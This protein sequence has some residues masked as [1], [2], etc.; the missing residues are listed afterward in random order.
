MAANLPFVDR[1]QELA[2][3]K[4]LIYKKTPSFVVIKGRRRIGKSRLIY[5]FIKGFPAYHFIGLAPEKETTAQSQRD[6]FVRQL[7]EQVELPP[8]VANDWGDIFTWLGKL[9]AEGRHIIVLDEVTWMGSFDSTFLGKLEVVWEKYFSKNPEL[10]V[11]LCGSVSQWIEDNILSSTGY[12]GR[13]ALEITL[14]EFSLQ[15]CDRFLQHLN[16][17]GSNLEKLQLLSITGGVP[18]YIE[19]FNPSISVS[20]NIKTLCFRKNALLVKEFERLFHDLFGKRGNIYQHIIQC[21]ADGPKEYNDIADMLNYTRSGALSKYLNELVISGFV[22][23][24][25]AWRLN[26]GADTKVSQYRLCDNYLRFYLKCIEPRISQINKDLFRERSLITIPGWQ[27]IMGM[28]FE[29]LVLHNRRLIWR[30]LSLKE[31]EII[32]DNPFLQRHSKNQKGCQI[33]YMIHAK[34]NILYICEI[35]FSQNKIGKGVIEEVQQKISRLKKPRGFAVK[36]ILIHAS[37]V[38]N[39]LIE[40]N[41][42]AAIINVLDFF[43]A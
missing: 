12:F 25:Y 31:E 2:T 8:I 7:H 29:N 17:R 39:N 28:Q 14:E 13:I 30:A 5:E 27:S 26:T 34:F 11:I 6:E 19:L 3:L 15:T 38:T 22:S 1:K 4:R 18:W 24:D 10:I 23:R 32:N 42:F 40:A 16:F 21:L 33:D 9:T 35:K 41:Y 37:E 36:P 20:E 43:E